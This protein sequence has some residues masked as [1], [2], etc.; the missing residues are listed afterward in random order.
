MT[1]AASLTPFA[2][3]LAVLLTLSPPRVEAGALDC[4]AA[5]W[6]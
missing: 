1:F 2:G 5:A 6:A 3:L 4:P